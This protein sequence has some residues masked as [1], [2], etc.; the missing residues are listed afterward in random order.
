MWKRYGLSQTTLTQYNPSQLEEITDG[1]HELIEE[2]LALFEEDTKLVLLSLQSN[3]E[4][5]NL[6]DIQRE[7][8]TIKGSSANVGAMRFS[9]YSHQ[10][11]KQCRG[12]I[13]TVFKDLMELLFLEFKNFQTSIRKQ[14]F[15]KQHPL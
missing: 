12:S 7:L 14:G 3:L 2:L 13:P 15:L 1:E 5:Q 8:H 9:F 10:I 11:E 4:K 6:K